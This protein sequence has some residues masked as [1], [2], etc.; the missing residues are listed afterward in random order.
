M[1]TLTFNSN[2]DSPAP[3]TIG[4]MQ[5][6]QAFYAMFCEE[7]YI[8]TVRKGVSNRP[9]Q[10]IE[11]KANIVQ[12]NDSNRGSS[13]AIWRLPTEILSQ[14]FLYCLPEDE[15]LSPT[16][17]MAPMS[18][19]A[20]CRRWRE[21]AVG[22]PSLWCK[23]W[24]E[25]GFGDWQQR[26]FYYD[27]CL[28][29]SQGCPLSLALQSHTDWSKLQN[30]LQ[31]YIR[32]ISSLSLCFFFS[33]SPFMMADFCA[34]EDLTVYKYGVDSVR[35]VHRSIEQ[36]PVNLRRLN[37]MDLSFTHERLDFFPDSP[38]ARLTT[39]EINLDGLDAFTRLLHLCPDLTSLTIIGTSEP[40]QALES[41]VHTKLQS[42]HMCGDLLFDSIGDLSLFDVITLPNLRV[43]EAHNMGPSQWPHEEFKAFL[44]RSRCPLEILIF[45][46]GVLTTDRQRAEYATLMPSLNL[47]VD[48]VRIDDCAT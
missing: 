31:P 42:L 2:V 22:L 39:L 25:V 26:A 41:V 45:G 35:A 27:S 38:W 23:L 12:T 17:S 40:I 47:I 14:I 4:V 46:G 43:V 29:R 48:P 8:E 32:Q 6:S 11:E 16:S 28:K 19:T 34:L 37:V 10:L 44:T 20:T 36:L 30:L 9:R 18:L 15:Y 24:L 1:Q 33:D 21:V 5:G 3:P 13:A 7:S